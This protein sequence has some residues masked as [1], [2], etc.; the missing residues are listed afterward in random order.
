M[1]KDIEGL[2]KEM[3]AKIREQTDVAVIGLSGGA[4]STLVAILCV[5][6]LGKENVYGLHLPYGQTDINY[7]NAR[8][9]QLADHLGINNDRI[10]IKGACDALDNEFHAIFKCH[11]S[12]L[13]SGNMRSRMRMISLYTYNC[14]ISERR[15]DK[16]CRVV[17]TGIKSEDIIGFETKYGD[18][19]VDFF[20]LGSFYK[21]EIF[22]LLDFFRD[23]KTINEEHIDRIPSAGLWEGQTDQNELGYTYD[24]MENSIVRLENNTLDINNPIDM[25]VQ[26][27]YLANKHKL[28]MPPVFNLRQYCD[29]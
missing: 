23:T 29:K 4:D 1:I 8:S 13:N 16:R 19:G 15:F 3:E 21:S 5:R 10:L 18:S 12:Q 28:E 9:Q 11:P 22:E 26:K 6:A 24:E 2:L 7:F 17:G 27:R 20:P 14:A 25:F